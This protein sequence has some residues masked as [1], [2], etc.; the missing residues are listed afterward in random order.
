[1]RKN[2]TS[3]PAGEDPALS[4]LLRELH[5]ARAA[6]AQAYL[7]FDNTVDEEL[8]DACVFEINAM[9]SRYNYLLRR[10]KEHDA[11]A[12]MKPLTEEGA[13]WV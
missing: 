4:E 9:Q 11:Q 6:L 8:V 12:A 5:D 2:K 13:K 10:I 1:M 3:Y 7:R